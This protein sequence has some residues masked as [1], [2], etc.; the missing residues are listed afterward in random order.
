MADLRIDELQRDVADPQVSVVSLLQ[1]AMPLAK[2]LGDEEF[3]KWAT[4]ELHGYSKED[5]TCE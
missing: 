5:S 2:R 3:I 4:Q 1:K